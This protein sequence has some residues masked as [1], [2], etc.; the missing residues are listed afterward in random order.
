MSLVTVV[1]TYISWVFGF[2]TIA[3]LPVDIALSS[4][5]KTNPASLSLLHGFWVIFY[6]CSMILSYLMI[7]WLMGYEISGEFNERE[8]IK[9]SLFQTLWFYVYLALG[10]SIFLTTLWFKGLFSM[11]DS[12]GGFTVR[13]FLMA[14]GGAA[15]LLQ[16]IVFLGYGLISVPK[17]VKFR[18]NNRTRFDV[19]LCRI[20]QYED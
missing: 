9:S 17:A 15:G 11:S 3:V 8:R 19:S 6:W 7:P 14:L 1:V 20:D 18:T 4:N 12:S 16:I 2:A 13:G 5:P 10:G